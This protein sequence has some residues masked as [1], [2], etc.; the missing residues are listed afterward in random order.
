L[1][2]TFVGNLQFQPSALLWVVLGFKA[3]LVFLSWLCVTAPLFVPPA[4][5]FEWLLLAEVQPL[6]GASDR[7]VRLR[8]I[9][10]R[11]PYS[12]RVALFLLVTLGFW[13]V[14]IASTGVAWSTGLMFFG[15]VTLLHFG[16]VELYVGLRMIG[17][18]L[19]RGGGHRPA[20]LIIGANLAIAVL[21]G[22]VTQ[23]VLVGVG[24]GIAS[25]LLW[26]IVG[27]VIAMRRWLKRRS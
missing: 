5:L 15:A 11:L 25:W 20:T 13:T 10:T 27:A 6:A 21:L 14:V 23:S 12:A 9:I 16:L 8:G 22:L 26:V 2:A 19:G 18:W 17:S 1:L 3:S 24:F 4:K 7:H